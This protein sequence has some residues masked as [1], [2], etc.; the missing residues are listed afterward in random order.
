MKIGAGK[1]IGAALFAAGVAAIWLWPK[2][3]AEVQ[4]EDVVRPVRSMVV[5]GRATLPEIRC[6]GRVRAGESRD[7]MF[8]VSGRLTQFKLDRGQRV[9]KGEVLA[10]LDTRDYEADVAKAEASFERA[11]LSRDRYANALGKGG[12]SK[13]DVSKVEAE[14]KTA[15]SE[16]AVAKKALEGC[17]LVAPYDGLVADKYPEEGDMITS[18]QKILTL[19]SVDKVKFDIT[20]PE[21]AVISRSFGELLKGRRRF[22]VFDSLPD[23][24]FAVEFEE[25]TT[26]ADAKTQTF[27]VTFSMPV[28][29]DYNI[30]PGMSVTLVIAGSD[31]AVNPD[32]SSPAA[33]PFTVP[34]VAVGADETGAHF[35]WKLVKADRDGE[36][37][38]VKQV[39]EVGSTYGTNLTVKKGLSEGDRIAVAGVTILTEGRVVTLWKE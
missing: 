30:L 21:T 34:A 36:Y 12:V 27:T 22:V 23:K 17:T 2:S 20:V 39:I 11:K 31:A 6:P 4:E 25:A 18:G 16:L 37:R 7:M 32:A 38:T 26:Q 3:K 5:S 19:L 1:I 33:V 24:E 13:E 14:F 15:S 10:K 8:E 9:K 35:V 28:Q 29:E